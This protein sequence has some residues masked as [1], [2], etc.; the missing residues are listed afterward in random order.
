[1]PAPAT[2]PEFLQLVRKSHLVP[3]EPLSEFLKQ[4]GIGCS[5][6]GRTEDEPQVGKVASDLVRSGLLSF[7]QAEKLLQGKWHGFTVGKYKV[8]ERLGRG[9]LGNVY[10][11]EHLFTHQRFAVK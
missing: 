6:A 9:G 7:F 10:L 11:C 4:Q 2:I 1:M 5:E 3:E 8:L